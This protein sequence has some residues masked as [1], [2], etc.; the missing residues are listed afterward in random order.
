MTEGEFLDGDLHNRNTQAAI[1]HR[2]RDG[3]R[4]FRRNRTGAP[5]A[6]RIQSIAMADGVR[7]LLD[8]TAELSTPLPGTSGPLA[9]PY[10]LGGARN[11]DYYRGQAAR[12]RVQ[13]RYV[14]G[15]SGATTSSMALAMS[16]WCSC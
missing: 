5:D 8:A 11:V 4:L 15:A 3:C 16:F 2:H 6:G 9:K 10:R 13:I 12:S 7:S 14:R 1:V